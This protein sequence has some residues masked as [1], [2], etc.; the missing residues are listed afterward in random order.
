[1]LV[2]LNCID[3]EKPSA[4]WQQVF[5]KSWRFYKE[6]FLLEGASARP[7]YLSSSSELEKFMP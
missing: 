1:M 7:G 4:K 6:W 5:Y 3:E 2:S